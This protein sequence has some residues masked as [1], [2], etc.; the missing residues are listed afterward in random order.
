[1]KKLFTLGIFLAM[2]I[3]IGSNVNAATFTSRLSSIAGVP[4]ARGYNVGLWGARATWYDLTG[5]TDTTTLALPTY[6]DDVIIP[7]TDSVFLGAAAYSR[8]LTVNGTLCLNSGA[9][10]ING[11]LTVNSTGIFSIKSSA[12]CKNVYNYGKIWA[13][14]TNYNTARVFG[15]GYT[16]QGSAATTVASSDSIT[17]YNDGIIGGSRAIAAAGGNGCGFYVYYSNQAKALNITGSE[18]SMPNRTFNAGGLVP[19]NSVSGTATS[20]A[21]TQNFNLYIR[22]G[23]SLAFFVSASPSITSLQNGD[24]FTGYTRTCTIEQGASMYVATSFHCKAS[25]P[26]ASQG[27]MA[28]NIYG[29]LDLG[30]YNR[31]KNEFDLYTS[32]GSNSV[33]VNV[34]NG[35]NLV[36]GKVIALVRSATDQTATLNAETGS[37]VTFGYTSSAPTITL[38]NTTFPTFFD[39]LAVATGTYSVTLPASLR[40]KNALTLTSGKLA[41]GSNNLIAGSLSGGS[42][43]SYVVAD[44]TGALSLNATTSGTLFP[45]GTATGYAPVAIMPVSNDTVSA[46]VSATPSGTYANYGINANEWTL[47]PQVATT[48]SLT[49]TPTTATN[50]TSPAIFSGIGYATKTDALLTSGAYAAAGFS[51][52]A[53]ATVFA[54]GGSLGTAVESNTINNLLIYSAKNSLVVKNAKAGDVVTVYGVSGLKVASSIVKDSNT[55]IVLIPGIYIVKSGSTIQKVSVQ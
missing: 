41:L 55:S 42:A 23:Q 37:N 43:T 48:A 1:M 9:M 30:T 13:W 7:A 35:G 50:V 32:T 34:K 38:T 24:V 16:N 14:S 10:Y 47:T 5:V 6:N 29:T 44:G 11:D 40:V 12:F 18:G 15:V 36:F 3:G 8:N 19:G 45:I 53:S 46:R 31:S 54:T 17:I 51:L 20:T 21:A 26:T 2:I 28:Y 25:A 4:T 39:N 22:N 27:A 33:S 49:L 52:P